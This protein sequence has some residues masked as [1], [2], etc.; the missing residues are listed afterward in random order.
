[1]NEKVKCL[2]DGADKVEADK[3]SV[4]E[5]V[6]GLSQAIQNDQDLAWTWHCNVAVTSLD[7][8]VDH[9]TANLAATRFMSTVFG[10]D[11]TTFEEWKQ[12]ERSWFESP[13]NYYHIEK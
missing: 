8:G 4:S 7:Q 1:M 9:K 5:L 13:K 12:F 6:E 2:N 11:V 10:V 3:N